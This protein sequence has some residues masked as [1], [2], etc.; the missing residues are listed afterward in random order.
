MRLPKV[1]ISLHQYLVLGHQVLKRK[2]GWEICKD[3]LGATIYLLP[4]ADVPL[5]DQDTS[6]VDG[7]GKSKLEDLQ[8][9][10]EV[11]KEK[12]F[13]TWVCSLRSRKSS[14]LRPST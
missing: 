6:V 10:V 3:P 4:N 12:K 11:Y 13:K 14:I 1:A 2:L 5:L 9:P 7:L 8:F